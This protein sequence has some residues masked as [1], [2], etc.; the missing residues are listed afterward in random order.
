MSQSDRNGLTYSDAGVDIDA[1]N[2]LVEKIKPAVRSTRRPGADGEIG[3]F[4]GLFDLKAAGF[5]DPV[6]VA[7]N[8]GVGTK[9]KIAIDAN[10]HDTVGIDLVAM[11]VN[12]LVVQGA[13]PLFFLDYFAT[14]KLD[15]DQGAAIVEGIAEGCR[16]SGCALIGGETA[17]MPGMYSR[18]DYDLAGFAVGAAE[19]G[20]L[21]PAGDLAEG[22]VILGLGS[23]GV[24]S[25]GFSLVR[26]IVELSGLAWEAPA[27][28][29]EGVSLGAALLTPTRIY[30]KPL[31]KTIRETGAIKALAHI[32]GGGFPENIPRVL[33]KHLAAE[34]DLASIK[35]PAVFSWLSKT[36]G[37]ARNEMLRTFNC[38][39]G[40]IVVVAAADAARV[41]DALAAEGETVFTLGR[42]VARE[43]GAPG[44]IY[45][46]ELAL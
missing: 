23:S 29:A 35:P 2:L 26:K 13:E 6:L 44:T 9:L 19:R 25:N 34:I 39:V 42:M 8:D 28:F 36:G 5:T 38:G 1:G 14:A 4:G 46:G 24:H 37:V 21:L 41:A 33:P 10:I 17:E 45:T 31:L 32:T 43:D 30:V 27:P 22:D 3:G 20:K 7:A 16:Q 11:C 18:G 40:M 12:D 15:P